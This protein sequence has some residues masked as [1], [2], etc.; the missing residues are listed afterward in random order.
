MPLMYLN[1]FFPKSQ[2]PSAVS[3]SFCVMKLSMPALVLPFCHD[4]M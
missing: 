3:F 1:D 2:E 4:E